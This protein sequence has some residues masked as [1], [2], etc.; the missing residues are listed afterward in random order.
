MR[1]HVRRPVDDDEL[2]RLHAEAFG[3]ADSPVPWSER[4]ERHSRSWVVAED[5]GRAV[6]FVHAVWDGGAHAFLLDTAVARSHRRHGVGRAVVAA[7][8]ADLRSLG[9]EWLHVD[10]EARLEPFHEA[11]GFGRTRAGLLRLSE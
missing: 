3:H 11:C 7:L 5:E 1:V 9:V 6:G 2:S 8:V 4:L 10:Y